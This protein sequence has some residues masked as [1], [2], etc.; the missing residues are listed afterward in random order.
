VGHCVQTLWNLTLAFAGVV[1]VTGTSA[2]PLFSGEPGVTFTTEQL[3]RGHTAYARSCLSCHGPSLE[4]TQFA[5]PLKGPA[6][7]SH[8]RGRPRAAFSTQMRTTMPPG[9]VSSL[10]SQAY[11]EIEAYI[12]SSGATPDPA[13]TP[14]SAASAQAPKA[15]RSGPDASAMFAPFPKHDN[16]PQYIAAL[17]AREQRLAGLTS[18]TDAMLDHPAQS[19]WLVWRRTYDA[20]GYSPL[21]QINRSN[22]DRL[23]AAWSWSLPQ[24]SNE[25]TP[26]VHDGVMFVYS[27]AAVQALDAATGNLLWQ[28]LRSL[29]EEF[30]NGH[31]AHAKSLAIYGDKLFAPTADGHIVALDTRTGHLLWDQEVVARTGRPA[32]IGWQLSG[33]PIVA[34]GKVIMGVS[35]GVSDGGGCYIV[36]LD[37]DSGKESW[38]FHTIARPGEPGGDTWNGAPVEERFGAGVWTAGS[39]DPELN[40]VY[41]GIGNTYDTATLLEPRPGASGVTSND[42]LYTDSTVALRPETGQLVWYYQHQKRDVWDLDWVFEQSVVT[43]PVNGQPRK[44]V[45]TG[46]KTA[47]FDAVDAATGKYVFSADLGFQNLVTAID[48]TTG[49]KTISP[50]VQPEAG[51]PKLIC[52]NS[53]GARNWPAT[54]INPDTHVLYTAI[55][56]NC[57]DYIYTP[58]S[59]DQ[60]AKGGLDER[61]VPRLS[62]GH[63]GNFGRVAAIDLQKRQVLWT[64]RQRVPLASS[65]LATGGGLLFEGDVD[66]YF[67][68]FDQS[69][70]KVLWRTRLNA[71][72]ESSP[73]TYA[74]EGKQYVA[75]VTGSGSPF[76][77]ASRAFVPEVGAPAASV[78]VMVFELP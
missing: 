41:F 8:W 6:F 60:T 65:A 42:G 63:D 5:P 26:L 59:A 21:H 18:V 58:R 62:A 17:K 10:S 56:E 27:G 35:L 47:L 50:A 48:P 75:V 43:L 37:A 76:G 30:N 55:L 31:N 64:Y 4:G 29:P 73:V 70:G 13:T 2:G 23:R 67:S 38:R 51:K 33:G 52:P 61:F 44:V 1:L 54:A 46:G 14:P 20:L 11:E 69:T 74:V 19:D 36:G 15:P 53:F 49:E 22:V 32:A 12:L 57:A 66:R 72:P 68:A 28:Y 34:R 3:E 40:L 71:S 9:G 7:E 39:Y 25:I 24:S 77:A 78:T 16:D 45:V